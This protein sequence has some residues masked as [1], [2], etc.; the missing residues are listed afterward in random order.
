MQNSDVSNPHL[1]HDLTLLSARPECLSK[2]CFQTA[3]SLRNR[4]TVSQDIGTTLPDRLL[5][6]AT[7]R[8]GWASHSLELDPRTDGQEQGLCPK[9]VR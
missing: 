4:E 5:S 1:A 3:N 2:A 7:Y 8:R 9:Q 6:E